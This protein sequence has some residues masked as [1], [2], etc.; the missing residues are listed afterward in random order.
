VPDA[1]IGGQERT[2]TNMPI[3]KSQAPLVRRAYRVDEA[4]YA[5]GISRA[6][7]YTAMREGKLPYFV[8]GGRRHISAD[9]IEALVRGE[10][11]SQPQPNAIRRTRAP[12]SGPAA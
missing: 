2:G 4:C 9:V 11:S 6:S 7:A 8:V 12:K 3:P 5:L 10:H 1:A